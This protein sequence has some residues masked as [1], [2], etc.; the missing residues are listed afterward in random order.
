MVRGSGSLRQVISAVSE[1]FDKSRL[2]EMMVGSEC[3]R[4]V[5]VLHDHNTYAI[6]QAPLFIQTV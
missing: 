4:N 6:G 3:L 2:L 1:Q 5:F